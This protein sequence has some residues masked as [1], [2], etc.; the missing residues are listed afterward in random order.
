ME[1]LLHEGRVLRVPHIDRGPRIVDTEE[2]WR[3]RQLRAAAKFVVILLTTFI[4]VLLM[5]F[6]ALGILSQTGE[7]AFRAALWQLLVPILI[8]MVMPY[9]MYAQNVRAAPAMPG[10][11]Q[12]GVQFPGFGGWFL[13]NVFVPFGQI[14]GVSRVRIIAPPGTVWL[15]LRG[16]WYPVRLFSVV[17][18]HE[19]VD[20]VKRVIASRT[21]PPTHD[22]APRLVVYGPSDNRY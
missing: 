21:A 1:L 11:Y 5:L 13:G 3:A 22:G 9:V 16:L 6:I 18:G 19:G 17:Y 2:Q 7:D 10:V 12:S 14:E 4:G 15:H 8:C 20:A